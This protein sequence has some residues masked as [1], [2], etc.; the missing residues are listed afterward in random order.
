MGDVPWQRDRAGRR[1]E[2]EVPCSERT[3]AG[4]PHFSTTGRMVF[5]PRAFDAIEG[6]SWE[7]VALPSEIDEQVDERGF[8]GRLVMRYHADGAAVDLPI[9]VAAGLSGGGSVFI[10]NHCMGGPTVNKCIHCSNKAERIKT[11]DANGDHNLV[12]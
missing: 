5:A 6:D 12:Q 4:Q 11:E 3:E 8:Q 10:E 7:Y 1:Q 2:T 9:E